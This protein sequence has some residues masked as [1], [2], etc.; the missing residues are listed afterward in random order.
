MVCTLDLST[1]G[2]VSRSVPCQMDCG[3]TC[4]LISY[5]EYCKIAQDGDPQLQKSNA[6]LR[7][8]DGSVMIPM[9][10]CQLHCNQ[11]GNNNL[12]YFQ[13]VDFDQKPL[14]S[15]TTCEKRELL[16]VNVSETVHTM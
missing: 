14:L 7:L 12:F 4:N 3:S 1:N 8:Y 15:A 10:T 5:T 9:G 6:K 2:Q 11:E 13:V 16:T